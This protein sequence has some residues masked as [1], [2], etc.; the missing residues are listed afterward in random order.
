MHLARQSITEE[1]LSW[2]GTAFQLPNCHTGWKYES[3]KVQ[4]DFSYL[5]SNIIWKVFDWQQQLSQTH[6][7]CSV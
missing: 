2:C 4:L 3:R 7:Q 1:A 5:P 6:S